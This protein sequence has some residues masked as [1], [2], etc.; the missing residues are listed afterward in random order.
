[1]KRPLSLFS[2]GLLSLGFLCVPIYA[3]GQHPSM[4]APNVIDGAKHPELV[5][6]SIA[7]RLFFLAA[8]E[9]RDA[10]AQEKKQ[11]K[12]I[13]APIRLMDSELRSVIEILATFKAAY[14]TRMDQYNVSVVEANKKGADPDLPILVAAKKEYAAL[15]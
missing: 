1:M 8:A 10:T 11:Q 14:R 12:A 9:L 2:A 5:P 4:Q 7:Y 3:S 6:D 13:L 15:R